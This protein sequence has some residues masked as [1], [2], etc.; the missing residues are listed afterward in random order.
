MQKSKIHKYFIALFCGLLCMG[1][2]ASGKAQ[3][4]VEI[5]NKAVD[6]Y[7]QSNGLTATF[8]MNARSEMQ[9][10]ADS[11][12]G[13][14]DIKGD[15]F[16]LKTPGMVTWYDGEN[17]WSYLESTDEVNLTVPEGDDL[18]MTNPSYLLKSYKKGFKASLKGESTAPNGKAA[19]DIV[20]TPKIKNDV[21]LVTLQLE[22]YSGLPVSIRFDM[23]NQTSSSIRVTHVKT[24]VNQPDDFFVF[25]E[26]DYPDAE[27]IDLR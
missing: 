22:K 27:V 16:V 2:M 24:G 19:Y 20:L 12:E 11:F 18:Q 1:N 13:T 14:I 15:R 10:N 23:K 26:E 25:N 3:D 17:Q 21:K 8:T 4:V 5:M 6:A 7:E 9:K